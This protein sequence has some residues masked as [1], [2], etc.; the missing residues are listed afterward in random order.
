MTLLRKSIPLFLMAMFTVM[1]VL[2]GTAA[3]HVVV[4][5]SSAFAQ[6]S[7]SLA[8]DIVD[9]AQQEETDQSSSAA[10]DNTQSF[11]LDLE[12]EVEAEVE[13]EAEQ[14]AGNV[15]LQDQDDGQEQ[16]EDTT[17]PTLIVPE[18]ITEEATGPDGSEV[19]FEVTAQDNVDGTF[20]IWITCI[21]IVQQSSRLLT[22]HF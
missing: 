10:D 21:H 16:E 1:G 20:Q 9:S 3:S 14:A 12:Q 7:S 6:T 17:P 15:A 4:K 2:L 13:N 8:Q 18:D 11:D 5:P 22:E 19:L